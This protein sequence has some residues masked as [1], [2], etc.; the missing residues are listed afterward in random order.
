MATIVRT[1]AALLI[2]NELLSGKT[3]EANLNALAKTLRSLGIRLSRVVMVEDERDVI[4]REVAELSQSF[5]L[6]VTSGGVGPTHDDVTLESVAQAFGTR[7]TVHPTLEQLLR[8]TYE[9]RFT[10]GHLRMALV[11]DGA[12]LVK[13]DEVHWPTVVMRN[14]WVFPG[15]P[16]IFRMKLTVLRENLRGPVEFH[17]RSVY[18][19]LEE[20]DLKPLLDEL[21]VRFPQVEI[22][23]YPKW[24]DTR[25]K[26]KV[27]FDAHT[28]NESEAA[29]L[30][31]EELL[32][33]V[34]A[35]SER[36]DE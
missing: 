10:E 15:V 23:S 9:E 27:T 12:N 18:T 7:A 25:Y 2:G 20:G 16:E 29:S 19:Q 1:A 32:T 5:D 17:S 22:G 3:V 35:R 4:A 6:V 34:G 13:S 8:D 11:P 31:L 24:F 36:V 30:A 26:T 33:Q 28:E 14:V 21:V